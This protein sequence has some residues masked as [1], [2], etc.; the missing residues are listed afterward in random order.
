MS[1]EMEKYDNK[2][3]GK[4]VFAICIITITVLLAMVIYYQIEK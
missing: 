3:G 2:K 4:I 1:E